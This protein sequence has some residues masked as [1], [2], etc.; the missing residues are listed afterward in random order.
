SA[1]SRRSSA[2]RRMGPL[3]AT[4]TIARPATEIYGFWRG[5]QNWHRFMGDLQRV[6][7]RGDGRF[8]LHIRGPAQKEYSWQLQS[9]E[10]HPNQSLTW[11]A[12]TEK[13]HRLYTATARFAAA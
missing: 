8:L 4:I 11:E 7:G 13:G 10:D 9:T 2:R 5:S 12:T 3:T 1:R 6:E